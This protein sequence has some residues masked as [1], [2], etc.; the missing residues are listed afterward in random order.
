VR[1]PQ[2]CA[3]HGAPTHPLGML[4]LLDWACQS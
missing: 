2:S 3:L 4:S 1:D